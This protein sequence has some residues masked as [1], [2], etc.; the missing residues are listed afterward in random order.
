MTSPSRTLLPP[1]Y[2]ITILN[3]RRNYDHTLSNT[4]VTLRYALLQRFRNSIR[5]IV[6]YWLI[7]GRQ[8]DK[9]KIENGIRWACGIHGDEKCEY[10]QNTGWKKWT[11]KLEADG[12][13]TLNLKIQGSKPWA[14]FTDLRIGT[15]G[16]FLWP[17]HATPIKAANFFT[18]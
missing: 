9:D 10:I 2:E 12:K 15:A 5:L 13:I 16:E 7:W 1:F 17:E 6:S 3:N 18:S 11:E 4:A 8:Y 14:V